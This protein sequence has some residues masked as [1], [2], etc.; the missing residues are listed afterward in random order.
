MAA[1]SCLSSDETRF[2]IFDFQTQKWTQLGTGFYSW[3]VFSRD[4]ES[5]YVLR[6]GG[7]SAVVKF[8]LTDGKSEEVVD[9]THLPLTGHFSDSSLAL[10]PDD[11]PLVFR[12][13]GTSD[14]YSLDWEEP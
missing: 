4:G 3:P 10:A 6:G 11:S 13:A 12:E 7:H 9:L 2:F 5:V 14:V 1:I 8:H